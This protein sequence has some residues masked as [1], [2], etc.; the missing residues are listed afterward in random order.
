MT[1]AHRP[2]W[3]AAVA[4]DNNNSGNL[5]VCQTSKVAN[6]DAANFLSIKTRQAGQGLPEEK[7]SKRDLRED[8][9]RKERIAAEEKKGGPKKAKAETKKIEDDNPFPEDADE[10]GGGEPEKSDDEDKS[11]D[12][13]EDTE[14]LMRE[15]AKI[16][17][18]REAEEAANNA[19]K[20]KSDDRARRDEIMK[21]NPLLE[22]G[23]F[24]LK[25]KWDDDTVFQNQSRTA[26]KQK[27]RYINDSVRSDFHRKFLNKY[28]WVDGVSH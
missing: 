14:E 25:R 10:I 26:P 6:R 15:L 2:T 12:D 16:K 22:T 9:E 23:D 8:L 18:E 21:G 24:S 19:V 4:G 11:D 17:K 13:D 27:E 5:M 1:T 3:N 28:V 7:G 20:K